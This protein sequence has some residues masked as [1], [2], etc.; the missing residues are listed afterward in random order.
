MNTAYLLLGSN[1]GNK[2]F[3]LSRAIAQIKNETGNLIAKSAL[4]DTTPW[5]AAVS[6]ERTNQNNFLNQAVCIETTQSAPQLLECLLSIEK[7]IGRIRNKKWEA[8]IID[9]DILFFNSEII[10]TPELIVPHPHLHERK[11]ALIPLVEIAPLLIHPV[12]KRSIKDILSTCKDNLVVF[13]HLKETAL[14]P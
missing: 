5:P 8:R 2:N 12:L 3:F 4:Y 13:P 7:K 14:Y 6:N 1:I 11:F 9:I 10:Q